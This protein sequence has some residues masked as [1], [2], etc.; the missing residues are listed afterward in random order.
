MSPRTLGLTGFIAVLIVSGS[1]WYSASYAKQKRTKTPPAVNATSAK[2][3]PESHLI[4]IYKLIGSGQAREALPLAAQ[5][6]KNF[7]T[8]QLGHLVYGDLLN[9]QIKPSAKASELPNNLNK[10]TNV[11]ALAELREE[12]MQ[13]VKGLQDRPL[14]GT[15]PSQILG[16]TSRNKHVIAVDASKSRLYILENSETGLKLIMDTYISVGKEGIGKYVQ[17]DLKTPLGV[18]YLTTPVDP[19]LLAPLYGGGALPINYPNPFDQRLGKSGSGIWLHGTMPERYSRPV[20][21]TDGCVVMANPDLQK[22]MATVAVKTTPVIIASKLQ[23]VKPEQLTIERNQFEASLNSWRETKNSEQHDRLRSFYVNDFNSYG[24]SLDTWWP[25]VQK[26]MAQAN[27]Q[28][29]QWHDTTTLAWH[30]DTSDKASNV[31]IVTY[32]EVLPKRKQ[33]VTKRQYWLQVGNQWK[34]FFEGVIAS[35]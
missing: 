20:K 14:P 22:L 1:L 7:P 4:A 34:I 9:M 12:S 17:G 27:K 3:G 31:M 5:L 6:T 13:R 15:I 23:W 33:A 25:T 10:A 24:K 32:D 30:P 35:S 28:N 26:E 18:Y 2:F 19:K 11:A 8:F 16:L 21:S 29:F